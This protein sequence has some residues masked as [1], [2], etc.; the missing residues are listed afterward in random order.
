M[1]QDLDR[2][3]KK[4]MH[5][6]RWWR[7][8]KETCSAKDSVMAKY[9]HGAEDMYR[10]LIR[11]GDAEYGQAETRGDDGAMSVWSRLP[12]QAAKLAL[13]RSL[14]VDCAHPIVDVETLTWAI[15]TCRRLTLRMFATASQHASHGDYDRERLR[16][17]QFLRAAPGGQLTADQLLRKM[18]LLAK[19]VGEITS[20]MVAARL[21]VAETLKTSGRAKTVFRLR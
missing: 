15:E 12:Q 11:A 2:M 8:R 7:K 20:T 10:E 9:T 19:Q 14:S 6:A 17:E 16:V 3:P 21:I 4:I 13:L 18:K 5:V 1:P